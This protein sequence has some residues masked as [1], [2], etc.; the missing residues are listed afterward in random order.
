MQEHGARNAGEIDGQEDNR[1]PGGKVL[2]DWP[3]SSLKRNHYQAIYCDP[4]WRYEVW[5]EGS[6]NT[7]LASS[8]YHVMRS[9]DIA[10]LPVSELAAKDCVLFMWITWP[11]ALD[12]FDIIKAWGFTYKTCAFSWIKG[13]AKQ[14]E[15]F[16]D[17]VAPFVGMGYWTRANSEACLLATR[18]NPKRLNADVRQ[19]IVEPRREHSRK[20]NCVYER[21][22]RLV[23]GPFVE[24]FARNTRP[25]WDSW[26]NETHKFGAVA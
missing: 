17:D 8:K 14:L 25:N 18:G 4:P 6:Q 13:D 19:A 15:F 10:S 24:L 1:E 9:K 12:A 23:S 2:S 11:Q 26:G 7:R 3:F 22:E 20:P 21:I 5:A 16:Q